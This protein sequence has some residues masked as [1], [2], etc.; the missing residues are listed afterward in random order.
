MKRSDRA[1]MPIEDDAALDGNAAGGL[2]A[3]A[4]G[5]DLTAALGTCA[6]CRTVSSVGVLRAYLGGP[7]AVLRCPACSGV[8]MRVSIRNESVVVDLAGLRGLVIS[9]S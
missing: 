8:V 7:A 3:D 4:F 9:A 6:H 5:L 2:L 1:F